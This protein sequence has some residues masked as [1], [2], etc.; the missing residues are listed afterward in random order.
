MKIKI[1]ALIWLIKTN[2]VVPIIIYRG[3]SNSSDRSNCFSPLTKTSTRIRT[4]NV[5]SSWM[6]QRIN[7]NSKS[8]SIVTWHRLKNIYTL[9]NIRRLWIIRESNSSGFPLPE[10]SSSFVPHLIEKKIFTHTCTTCLA[11]DFREWNRKN[12]KNHN[13]TQQHWQSI[14]DELGRREYRE[15][16][17]YEVSLYDYLPLSRL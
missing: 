17:D 3:E 10:C 15:T 2:W 14:N 16:R 4:I 13:S 8:I 12:K 7:N 1:I 5:S 9:I 6:N 11:T